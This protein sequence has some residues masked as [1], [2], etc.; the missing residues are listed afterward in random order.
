MLGTE[1]ELLDHE[2]DRPHSAEALD[3]Q[4]IQSPTEFRNIYFVLGPGVEKDG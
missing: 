2:S 4:E 1:R 3:P